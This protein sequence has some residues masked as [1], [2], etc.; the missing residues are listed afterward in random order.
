MGSGIPGRSPS[1]RTCRREF[2][3]RSLLE[4]WITCSCFSSLYLQPLLFK[5]SSG[6]VS[7]GSPLNETSKDCHSEAA[8]RRISRSVRELARFFSFPFLPLP[9]AFSLLFFSN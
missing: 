2:P 3:R 9:I 7:L 8:G 1:L 4:G 5:P 6:A